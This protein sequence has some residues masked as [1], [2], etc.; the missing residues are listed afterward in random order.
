[1]S[2]KTV[3]IPEVKCPNKK[4]KASISQSKVYKTR[5]DRLSNRKLQYRTCGTCCENYITETSL[6]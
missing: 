5:L 4:C 1:M 2:I 3:K 6:Y